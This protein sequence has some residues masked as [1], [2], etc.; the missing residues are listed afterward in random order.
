MMVISLSLLS[1]PS[2]SIEALAS[3]WSLTSLIGMVAITLGTGFVSDSAS[4]LQEHMRAKVLFGSGHGH[5]GTIKT[6]LLVGRPRSAGDHIGNL[7]GKALDDLASVIGHRG[8][9]RDT[10]EAE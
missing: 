4:P 7:C 10:R 9:E 8:A 6:A 2:I 1:S 5:D 3:F